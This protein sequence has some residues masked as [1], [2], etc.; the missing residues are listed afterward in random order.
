VDI[1]LARHGPLA[2]G[3]EPWLAPRDLADWIQRYHCSSITSSDPPR[4]IKSR[5]AASTLVC[6]N[7][8]RC[9]QSAQRIDPGREILPDPIYREAEL[10]HNFWSYP[11]L[12]P[13]MWAVVFRVAWLCGYT[14]TNESCLA[15]TAR[16]GLAA[17]QLIAVA[18][19]RG[20]VLLIGH[21]IMNRL[22]GRQLLMLG[23]HGP[24]R[25]S[26]A[27]WRLTLYKMQ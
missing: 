25:P 17:Q 2:L 14:S 1:A 19:A 15:A 24:R 21:G 27:H 13:S 4:E 16:A 20:P 10:P 22:I 18:R 8:A 11:K 7:A 12:P 23:C 26:S 3:N 9:L 5:A 6:S